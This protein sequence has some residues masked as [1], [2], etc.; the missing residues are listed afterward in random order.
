MSHAGPSRGT[1]R[2]L[3]DSLPDVVFRLD[4]HQRFT[5]VSSAGARLLGPAPWPQPVRDAIH[6]AVEGAL[7]GEVGRAECGHHGRFYRVRVVRERDHSD[8]LLGVIE[9]VTSAR[10]RNEWRRVRDEAFRAMNAARGDDDL[11]DAVFAA[12]HRLGVAS[13]VLALRSATHR[14]QFEVFHCTDCTVQPPALSHLRGDASLLPLLHVLVDRAPVWVG[15]AAEVAERFPGAAPLLGEHARP[16]WVC[17][18]IVVGDELVGVLHFGFAEER[19]YSEED[20]QFFL[21]LATEC[22]RVVAHARTRRD[23][24]AANDVEVL[25]RALGVIGHDLRSPLTAIILTAESMIEAKP[26]RD[27]LRIRRSALRMQRMISEILDIGRI[28][29]GGGLTV[30]PVRCDLAEL[31]ADQ[32]DELTRVHPDREL[33]VHITGDGVGIWDP[34][35]IS[36]LLSN[37]IGNA[38]EHGAEGPVDVRLTGEEHEVELRVENRGAIPAEHR[39]TIFEP[40]RSYASP[41]KSPGLGLGLFISRAIVEAHSGRIEAICDGDA[42]AFVVRLPRT[43]TIPGSAGSGLFV[44][45]PRRL[46]AGAPS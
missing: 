11:A 35:R 9:D 45:P 10:S 33:R 44:L 41:R 26:T 43:F 20:R 27:A 21:S 13:G 25:E 6:D 7:A 5:F 22:G 8:A 37:L 16:A 42:T 1:Y 32:V 2:T 39:A 14:Y 15:S 18:P 38:I 19:S 36:E 28:R 12:A 34:T 40:F 31:I 23:D 46:S 30:E 24:R 3:V 17:L 29:R 4:R